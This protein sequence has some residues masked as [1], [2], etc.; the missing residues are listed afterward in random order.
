MVWNGILSVMILVILLFGI[1]TG[2]SSE[3]NEVY[4]ID[5]PFPPNF[6]KDFKLDSLFTKSSEIRRNV[7]SEKTYNLNIPLEKGW[8]IN[9][10]Q[11]EWPI[12]SQTVLDSKKYQFPIHLNY[13]KNNL[14][15][16]V[17][18]TRQK[19]VFG[20]Q[21]EIVY[22]NSIIDVLRRSVERGN[23]E[24]SSISLTF[25]GG[26]NASGTE[27]ILNALESR[28]IRT[29]IFLTGQFI[30]KYP[31]LVTRMLNSNQEIAN[32]TFNHPHLTS[33]NRNKQQSTLENVNREFIQKQL[34]STDSVFYKLTGEH[35][36]P[37]WRAPYGEYNQQILDW[38]AEC[39]YMHIRWTKGFDTFDWVED[40]ESPIYKSSQQVFENIINK[41]NG[42]E[43]LNGAI[44]LMH[45]GSNRTQDQVYKIIPN[46]IDELRSRDYVIVPISNLLNL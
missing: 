19:I 26:A 2:K 29:T 41:D 42:K 10:W 15:I 14:K 22:R 32:H 13:G 46:L 45:L 23:S 43:K 38:A 18:D 31:E 4:E 16:G 17:W 34:L 5:H 21:F 40:K 12:L 39:G 33:Y 27:E 6:L 35:M 3:N 8:V 36:A 28:K 24:N 11:N 25:D 9:I 37:F 30:I 20:D 7:L 44:V 1:N